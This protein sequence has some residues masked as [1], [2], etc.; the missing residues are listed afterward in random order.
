MRTQSSYS[1]PRRPGSSFL[2]AMAMEMLSTCSYH[3]GLSQGASVI[4]CSWSWEVGSKKMPLIIF[5]SLHCTIHNN[6]CYFVPQSHANQTEEL[7]QQSRKCSYACVLHKQTNKPQNKTKKPHSEY[8]YCFIQNRVLK[9][10]K[11]NSFIKS[12]LQHK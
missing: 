2:A 12:I 1:S 10:G 11:R 9:E 3:L 8:R 5:L 7:Q 4:G 6:S